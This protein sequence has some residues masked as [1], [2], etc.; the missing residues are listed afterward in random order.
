MINQSDILFVLLQVIDLELF[1]LSYQ[2]SNL[3]KQA[4]NLLCC[5]Y[6]IR[7]CLFESAKIQNIVIIQKI[8]ANNFF[9]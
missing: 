7:Q 3:D 6:T 2:D 4:Q 1:V 8:V 9:F 5:H